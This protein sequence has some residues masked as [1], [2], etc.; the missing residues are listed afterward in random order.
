MRT[1]KYRLAW[2]VCLLLLAGFIA[3]SISS[4]YVSRDNVRKTI[5]DSSLPLTSDNIYSVIQRDLLQPVF[6]SSMMANDAFL[7]EWT[8]A[9]EQDVAPLQRYLS[10]I[11]RE[12]ET[13][14]S[15]F[16]SEATRNYYYFGGILKQVDPDEYRDI[17]YFRVREMDEAFE[18]NVDYDM[19]NQDAMTIF[20][21]YRVYDF[22]GNFIGATG[23]G[24]TV[25]RVNELIYEYQERF[26]REIFFV[27]R[28]GEIVLGPRSIARFGDIHNVPGLDAKADAL[29]QD[30][31]EDFS[32]RRN[33]ETYFVNSRFVPELDWFLI[34]EQTENQLLAPLRETLFMNLGL[35]LLI[36]CIVAFV[37]ISAIRRHQHSLE[38]QNEELLFANRAIEAQKAQLQ[39]SASELEQVN[40]SLA[41]LNREKDD[42]LSIVAH[43]LRNPLN[44]VLGFSE[45]IR[46][47]LPEGDAVVREYLEE[48]RTSGY[49]MLDLISDILNVSSIE[50]F[51][52]ELQ[53]NSANW[54]ELVRE[55]CDLVAGQAAR[56]HIELKV[57]L[58]PVADT[59][60][61]TRSKWMGICFNNLLSNAIKYAPKSS[62]VHVRT[63]RGEQG[64]V[65][66]VRD[67]GPGLRPDEINRVFDKFVRLSSKPT[68]GETSTG[69]GLYIVQKMCKRLNAT[70]QVES[71]F[72][73][74]AVF[75]ICH[76]EH[77]AETV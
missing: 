15:F 73:H 53:L 19:A 18:I 54:N 71:E 2:I 24:L 50:S 76:P 25:T 70:V 64:W 22:D 74:G 69:L 11:R 20:V 23:T 57:E 40:R 34:V 56:K 75:R 12:Y 37:C 9:G 55:A 35:A 38:S 42:F 10:E 1:D 58:D 27:D 67:Q 43:D 47:R 29:L 14:T 7:R 39:T 52:G 48:I 51:N 26:G 33:G 63:G 49:H 61:R 65:F 3:N 31:L 45:E 21:N 6:I 66:E 28:A 4:Y 72:G 17:W 5:T 41:E 32:Y 46:H 60:V 16:V 8:I 68:D 30:R 44:G 36:T 59:E 13:V 62:T 77:L